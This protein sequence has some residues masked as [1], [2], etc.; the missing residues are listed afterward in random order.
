MV[1]VPVTVILNSSFRSRQA[2]QLFFVVIQEPIVDEVC[3]LFNLLIKVVSKSGIDKVKHQSKQI[4]TNGNVLCEKS[5]K[6]EVR[7]TE[8]FHNHEM[9]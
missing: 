2:L 6:E 5:I 1:H 8:L 3:V 7:A 4:V 9:M